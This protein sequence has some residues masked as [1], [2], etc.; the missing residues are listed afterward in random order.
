[1]QHWII[2]NCRSVVNT[3][4]TGPAK[5]PDF[6]LFRKLAKAS[7]L[8]VILFSSQSHLFADSFP[9]PYQAVYSGSF[10]GISAEMKQSLSLTENEQWHLQNSASIAFFGFSEEALFTTNGSVITP[11]RYKYNN[12]T[13][14]KRS[15]DLNFDHDLGTA[16]DLL[17]SKAP[18]SLPEGALDKLSFQTQLRTDLIQAQGNFTEK[19]YVLVDRTKYKNYTVKKLADVTIET[20]I[21]TFEAVKLEQRRS[22]KESFTLIW[23]AKNLDH[24]ILRIQRMDGDSSGREVNLQSLTI[25]GKEIAHNE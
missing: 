15:S 17:H 3:L 9:V 14:S 22:G 8:S 2:K 11:Q 19:N 25:N 16:I 13:S 6:T 20:K 4:A 24:F 5:K 7:S 10:A 12:S 23:T 21:G 18:L 1:M